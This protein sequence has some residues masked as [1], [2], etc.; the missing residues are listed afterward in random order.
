MFKNLNKN[1][2][3]SPTIQYMLIT[4]LTTKS[5]GA[6]VITQLAAVAAI[7]F[8]YRMNENDNRIQH[9]CHC[10][11]V[12]WDPYL[13]SIK[14]EIAVVFCCLVNALGGIAV[15]AIDSCSNCQS[16]LCNNVC[17]CQFSTG[18]SL[19]LYCYQYLVCLIVQFYFCLKLDYVKI[20]I[21]TG[22]NKIWYLP[23]PIYM[24]F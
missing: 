14:T 21:G 8:A 24:L 13:P 23:N 15:I 2:K 4:P 6:I 3:S 9:P 20:C 17:Y 7:E 18:N 16:A 10:L 1:K 12:C 5:S 11:S 22:S 19:K